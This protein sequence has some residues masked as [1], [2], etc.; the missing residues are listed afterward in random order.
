MKRLVFALPLVAIAAAQAYAAIGVTVVNNSGLPIDELYASAPGKNDWGS[1]LLEGVAEGALDSG[2][3]LTVTA[4]TDGTYDLR[5]SAPD[6]GV[7]CAMQKVTIRRHTVELTP[8]MG[9]ACR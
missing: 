7:L 3:S 1:N 5:I 2:K 4:L 6:E 8:D 9:K